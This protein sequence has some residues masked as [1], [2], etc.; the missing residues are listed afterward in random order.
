VLGVFADKLVVKSAAM[1]IFVRH[2]RAT[3]RFWRHVGRLPQLCPPVWHNDKFHWRKVFDHNP[4]FE[5]F[6]DKLAC[7]QWVRD[8][9]PDLPIPA[10]LWQGNSARDIP[11]HLL[12]RPVFISRL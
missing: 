9:C 6:C 8:R 5:I 7:K 1:V 11:E 4:A 10:T 12:I 3:F 2:W